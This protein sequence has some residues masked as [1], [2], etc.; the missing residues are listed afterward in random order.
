M[1]PVYFSYGNHEPGFCL[2]APIQSFLAFVNCHR[3]ELSRVD[4]I[5]FTQKF[6][7]ENVLYHTARAFLG[8][9]IQGSTMQIADTRM[10][11]RITRIALFWSTRTAMCKIFQGSLFCICT[12]GRW[13]TGFV[14][15]RFP[16]EIHLFAFSLAD[17]SSCEEGASAEDLAF[18]NSAVESGYCQQQRTLLAETP[19]VKSVS[20][21]Q[22][23][24]GKGLNLSGLQRP[25]HEPVRQKLRFSRDFKWHTWQNPLFYY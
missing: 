5:W 21:F 15:L 24:P 17:T 7:W 16:S 8:T 9:E 23:S 3:N 6:I 20:S 2:T 1:T 19:S 10:L 11:E 12:P 4:S 14:S 22:S 13:A 18:D 25:L